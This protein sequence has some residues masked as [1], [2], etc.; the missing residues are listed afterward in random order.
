[1]LQERVPGKRI[2][3][4]LFRYEALFAKSASSDECLD[5]V[6]LRRGDSAGVCH[7][8]VALEA[9]FRDEFL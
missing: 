8:P 4:S 5:L 3:L 2:S 9:L 7:E 6:L 1:M